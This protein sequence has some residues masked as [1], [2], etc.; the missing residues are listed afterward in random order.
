MH[1]LHNLGMLV[2]VDADNDD[3]DKEASDGGDGDDEGAAVSKAAARKKTRV[4]R[5]REQRRRDAEVRYT[6]LY[7]RLWPALGL[8]PDQVLPDFLAVA[9]SSS[10][11]SHS[12]GTDDTTGVCTQRRQSR[13]S[14]EICTEADAL[15]ASLNVINYPSLKASVA[16]IKRV[17]WAGGD[18]GACGAQGA[19]ARPA[20]PGL[21]GRPGGR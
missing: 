19:A 11:H 14:P 4:D 3:G 5:N 15:D 2:Q 21:A 20:G 16:P 13:P 7:C 10:G 17:W 1:K 9:L 18:G 6:T 8:L 12:H